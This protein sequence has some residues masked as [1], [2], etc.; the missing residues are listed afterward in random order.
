MHGWQQYEKR[1]STVEVFPEP[2]KLG[3]QLRYADRRGFRLALIAGETEF[4]SGVYQLKN[5]STGA[6]ED[7]PAEGLVEA[8]RRAL[9]G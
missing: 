6:R 1:L 5:L 2:K 7:V 3:H 9:A 8:V 4:A